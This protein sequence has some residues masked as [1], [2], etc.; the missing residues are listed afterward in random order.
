MI[1]YVTN[2]KEPEIQLIINHNSVFEAIMVDE[3]NLKVKLWWNDG[4]VET[5]SS[6]CLS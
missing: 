3:P 6:F 4:I 5:T 1:V 2:N